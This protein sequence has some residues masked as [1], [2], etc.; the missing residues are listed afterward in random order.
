M[1]VNPTFVLLSSS[2]SIRTP[3]SNMK[4]VSPGCA[5]FR[6]KGSTSVQFSI[7]FL[8]AAGADDITNVASR[9][10]LASALDWDL[11]GS[12]CTSCWSPP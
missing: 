10:G 11:G 7:A 2:Y 9:C 12:V 3:Q 5:G 1:Q 4:D 6:L 8:T